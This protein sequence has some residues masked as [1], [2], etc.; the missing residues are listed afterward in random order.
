MTETTTETATIPEQATGPTTAEG[1][2]EYGGRIIAALESAW[3]AIRDRHPDVP[4]VVMITGTVQQHGGARWGHFGAK[5]WSV[6]DEGRRA[7]ELFIAGELFARGGRS[8]LQTMLHEAAHSLAAARGIKDTSSSGR[9]HNKRF[10]KLAEELGLTGP[11]RPI[12]VHGW[13]GVTLPDDTA[14]K[15]AEVIEDIDA[16][17]LPYLGAPATASE[18]GEESGEEEDGQEDGDQDEEK[19]KK[20]KGRA[21]RRFR[22]E[23]ECP[24]PRRLQITPAVF[25]G[26]PILCGVC[27]E[28]FAAVDQDDE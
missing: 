28:P 8:V 12:S 11:Q 22:V 5:F 2:S 21:G 1:Q 17:R 25:E 14:K 20:G 10:V 4:R 27:K 18:G 9:Y 15:Y 6:R 23:C 24:D 19:P 7:D 13:T 26:G 3:T 16:A